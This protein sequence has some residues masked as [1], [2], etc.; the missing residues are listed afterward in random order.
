MSPFCLKK[1]TDSREEKR[2]H[3]LPEQD[4]TNFRTWTLKKRPGFGEQK[5][6]NGAMSCMKA[7]EQVTTGVGLVR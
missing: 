2:N 5:E 4:L 3:I 7:R 6:G 1:L